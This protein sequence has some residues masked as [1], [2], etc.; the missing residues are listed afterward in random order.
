ML[1][2]GEIQEGMV[3]EAV[4]VAARYKL[5]N[6]TA[7]VDRNGLQQFGLPRSVETRLPTAVTGVIPGSVSTCP[8]CSRPSAGGS[9]RSTAMISIRSRRVPGRAV[10]RHARPAHRR[11]CPHGQGQGAVA[12]RGSTPGTASSRVP[13]TSSVPARS[14]SLMSST[15]W[16]PTTRPRRRRESTGRRPNPNGGTA[17]GHER[18]LGR[19]ARRTRAQRS[20]DHRAGR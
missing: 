19:Q 2:D 16:T 18:R 3:W 13:R 4:Q 6:L 20:A 12:G 7:I 8:R 9:S 15:C 14:S 11:H 5:S 17:E 1:G 10:G